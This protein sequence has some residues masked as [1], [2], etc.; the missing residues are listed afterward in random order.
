MLRRVFVFKYKV[1]IVHYNRLFNVR[2]SEF[3]MA[4]LSIVSLFTMLSFV[5]YNNAYNSLFAQCD[6]L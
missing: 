5:L 3:E 2:K 4:S 1:A 6:S